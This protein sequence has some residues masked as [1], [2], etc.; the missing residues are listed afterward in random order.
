MLVLLL[1]CRSGVIHY[2]SGSDDLRAAW[3]QTGPY[4]GRRNSEEDTTLTQTVMLLANTQ[5]DCADIPTLDTDKK[6]VLDSPESIAIFTR[7]NAR[8][9]ILFLFQQ[10][11]S[12]LASTYIVDPEPSGENVTT[13][14][15]VASAAY[16]GV[17][18]AEL[19]D[20][21]GLMRFYLPGSN[22]GDCELVDDVPP[23]G[24]IVI[25]DS[26]PNL[27]GT[28][29][30]DSIDVSGRFD[31]KECTDNPEF[32]TTLQSVVLLPPDNFSMCVDDADETVPGE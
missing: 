25:T 22:P 15:G 18:E 29:A 21:D 2:P 10:A 8:V 32:M 9:V 27:R 23:P 4:E 1:A 7:E 3:F 5:I 6:K 20:E 16:L 17:N 26:G 14:N 11:G 31:A 13:Q 12:S 24:E 19:I 30:L 28:F